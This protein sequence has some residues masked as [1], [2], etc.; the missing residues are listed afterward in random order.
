MTPFIEQIDPT[1]ESGRPDVRRAARCGSSRGSSRRCW[2]RASSPRAPRAGPHG[3]H[4]RADLPDRGPDSNTLVVALFNAMIAAGIRAQQSVDAMAVDLHGGHAGVCSSSRCAS[5]TRPS[6]SPRCVRSRSRD[7]PMPMTGVPGAHLDVVVLGEVLVEFSSLTPL[8]DGATVRL[9]FSGDALNAAA[10]AVAAVPAR[11]WSPGCP[12]TTSA[13]RWSPGSPS[14]ASTPGG[15]AG[16]PGATVSM[17][18]TPTRTVGREFAYARSGSMGSTLSPED[19][20]EEVLAGAGV[21]VASGVACAVSGRRSGSRS[22]PRGG[23]PIRVRPQLPAT[24]HHG[25]QGGEMLREPPRTPSSSRRPG[26]RRRQSCSG[27]RPTRR[28]PLWRNASSPWVARRS[29]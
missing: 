27:S 19:L 6:W 1:I 29:R 21:V 14:W 22:A 28:H 3:R 5:S 16:S 24:A 26:P 18:A 11:H 25:R 17:S 7:G 10:A 12:A 4:V 8:A 9:G 15:S 2:C 20:D 23:A 13:T